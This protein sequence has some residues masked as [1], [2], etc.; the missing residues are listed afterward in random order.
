[1]HIY[2]PWNFHENVLTLTTSFIGLN[3]SIWFVL[4]YRP[5]P[6]HT[7]QVKSFLSTMFVAKK[8]K[9]QVEKQ[10]QIIT[11]ASMAFWLF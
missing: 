6:V 1:M 4:I 9:K 5:H 11:N 10:A 7:N 8:Y 3:A 2:F